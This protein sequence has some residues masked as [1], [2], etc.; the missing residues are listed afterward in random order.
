[1]FVNTPSN[2]KDPVPVTRWP[3]K[4]PV[5]LIDP[6]SPPVVTVPEVDVALTPGEKWTG[7]AIEQ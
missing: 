1:M 5:Q 4:V 6:A 7:T 3:S 2:P